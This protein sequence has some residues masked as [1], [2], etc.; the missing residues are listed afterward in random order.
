MIV[1]PRAGID[2]PPIPGSFVVNLGDLFERWTNKRYRSTPHRVIHP[3]GVERFSAPFFFTGAP[4]YSVACL[5]ACLD[6]GEQPAYPPTTP[7]AHLRERTLQ[8]GF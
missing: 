7:A 4:N 1:R 2:A 6:D 3:P 5:P 8:Q